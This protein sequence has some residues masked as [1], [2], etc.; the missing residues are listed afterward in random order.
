V[1]ASG[2]VAGGDQ[3]RGGA[4]GPDAVQ[5]AQRRG[6]AGGEGVE[7]LGEQGDLGV[8]V[9]VAAGQAAQGQPGRRGRGGKRARLERGGGADQPGGGQPASCSR[10]SAGAVTSSPLRALIAWVRAL[11]AVWRAVRSARS[12]STVPSWA[13]GTPVAWP[14][15]TARAA[16][17]ASTASLLPRRR[18]AARSGR[19]TSTTRWWW[20][21]R[22]RASP[23]P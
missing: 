9:L 11:T 7:L 14:A 10:S 18:R 20:A 17:S 21:A 13:L 22:K 8:E 23:A 6:V 2:V 4:V 3:Q 5:A 12:I 1:Q 16:A 15:C 19:L